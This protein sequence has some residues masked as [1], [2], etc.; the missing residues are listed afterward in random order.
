MWPVGTY[1]RFL[2]K[3]KGQESD[4]EKVNFFGV[5]F[6]DVRQTKAREYIMNYLDVF[7]ARSGKYIDFYIPGYIP[8]EDYY[9]C[10]SCESNR[11]NVSDS[12]YIFDSKEYHK[13]CT[14]FQ[15]DFGVE[16]PFSATLVLME[17]V[18][19]NFSTA[20]KIVF[21]LE[22]SDSGIK[23]AG[24]FFLQI[25]K[26]AERGDMPITLK[27]LSLKLSSHD[28]LN[29]IPIAA[30]GILNFFGIDLEPVVRQYQKIQKYKVR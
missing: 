13:F 18:K 7:N 11:I 17:Y 22:D 19:G 20:K 21:E 6:C 10:I 15:E 4:G 25:F 2:R 23:S 3:I 28:T 26:C 1:E 27:E 30:N 14:S 12:S 24:S 9:G 29:T 16:F 5:L 8:E